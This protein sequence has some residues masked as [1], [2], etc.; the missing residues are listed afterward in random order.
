MITRILIRIKLLQILYAY[1]LNGSGDLKAAENELLLSLRKSYDLYHYFLQLIVD[2]TNLHAR[3]ADNRKHKYMPTYDEL[4]PNMRLINNRF[5]RQLETTESLRSYVGN[6]KISWANDTDFLRGILDSLL[7]SELYA[8]YVADPADTYETDKTFWRAA[9]KEQICRQP[10]VDDY[11]EDKS[12]YWNEDIGIVQTFVLKTIKR[13]REDEGTQHA[14]LPMFKNDDDRL[15]AIRLLRTTL[16][17]GPDIRQRLGRHMQN[18]EAE[19][20]AQL[21]MIILQTAVA[22]ILT[23]P[24]I[25]VSVSMNEYIDAAKYYGTPKSGGFINGILESVVSELKKENLLVK[26]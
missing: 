10:F 17:Q 5:A 4:H 25:P 14:L 9:F 18:W 12:I 11:L 19:R 16:L 23:F 6:Y 26:G 2:I 8:S 13:M 24:S 21:D 22:E 7:A 15:F 3:L 1:Y 20:V